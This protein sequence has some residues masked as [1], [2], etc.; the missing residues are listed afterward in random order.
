MQVFNLIEVCPNCHNIQI[1]GRIE[2][3]I[4]VNKEFKLLEYQCEK[5][6]YIIKVK[7]Q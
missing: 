7:K 2:F 6:K 1:V 5:C 4:K 3:S